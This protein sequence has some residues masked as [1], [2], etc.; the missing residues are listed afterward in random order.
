MSTSNGSF[1]NFGNIAVSYINKKQAVTLS[2]A[3]DTALGGFGAR[4]TPVSSSN[5]VLCL[6]SFSGYQA[7]QGGF[8]FARNG[9]NLSAATSFGSRNVAQFADGFNTTSSNSACSFAAYLDS[10]ATTSV[11]T[12]TLLDNNQGVAVSINQIGSSTAYI[13]SSYLILLEI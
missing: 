13:G 5:N 4:I 7:Q 2:S 10:P 9:T 1:G 6:C 3:T 8:S 12:Y 11:T